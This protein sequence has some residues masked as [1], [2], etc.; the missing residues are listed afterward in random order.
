MTDLRLAAIVSSFN[1]LNLLQQGLPSLYQSL[2][3]CPFPSS[4]VVFEAGSTDGSREWLDEF[5]GQNRKIPLEVIGP[6]PGQ[7]NSFSAGVNAACKYAKQKYPDV[8]H[9]FLF[10]TDN[11]IANERPILLACQLL[12]GDD[13][14]AAAGFTV[15]KFAGGEAGYGC[16][17]PTLTE[18]VLGQ[19]L[20]C[21]LRL[22]APGNPWQEFNGSRWRKCDV[23]FTSPLMVKSSAWEQSQ[24]F[25]QNEFPFS[26]CDTDWCRRLKGGGWYLAVLETQDVVHDNRA[27]ISEW[28]AKRAIQFHK[29]RLKYLKRY[30]GGGVNMLKP[31]LFLRHCLEFLLV[32]FLVLLHKRPK[33]VLDVRGRLIASVFSDYCPD[34]Q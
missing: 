29:A 31:L 30:F 25:D 15:R 11:W 12:A 28:S 9:F 24:G 20:T 26:D 2:E 3:Q 21:I 33:A 6:A 10:E 8:T 13:K 18:F 14:L 34:G 22:D 7:D 32:L 17:F 27:Q 23:V 5:I 4:I 1:R 19:H 16:S